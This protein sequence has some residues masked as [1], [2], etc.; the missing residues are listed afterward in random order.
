[1]ESV[2]AAQAVAAAVFMA[3]SGSS[4]AEIRDYVLENYCAIPFTLDEIRENYCF[5]VTCQGSVPQA[6]EAFF[7]SSDFED[8]VRNAIS[9]GG[10]SDTIAA[11]AGSI[12]GAYYGIPDEIRSEALSF[13]DEYEFETLNAFEEFCTNRSMLST[14]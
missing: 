3:R 6:F 1:M 13:L 12:A 11:I 7:E 8:A 10:D 9:I 5:D 4:M 14:D 2:K